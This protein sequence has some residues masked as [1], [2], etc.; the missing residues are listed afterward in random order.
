MIGIEQIWFGIIEI[1]R[2]NHFH[3][4]F[5]LLTTKL[6]FKLDASI[7]NCC[8]PLNFSRIVNRL[9]EKCEG[10]ASSQVSFPSHNQ[11]ILSP[12]KRAGRLPKIGLK[13]HL[14]GSLKIEVWALVIYNGS[15]STQI[16]ID[17][18]ISQNSYVKKFKAEFK[19]WFRI[20]LRHY[21]PYREAG[22]IVDK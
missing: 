2:W 13:V 20:I 4:N 8:I 6:L 9:G 7:N 1:R 14:K 11:Y 12:G 5:C 21:Y 10:V 3:Q 22:P 15:F 16:V 19:D 18:L 17:F